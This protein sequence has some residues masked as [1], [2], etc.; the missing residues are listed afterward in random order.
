M[1]RA[2]S[3]PAAAWAWTNPSILPPSYCPAKAA[4]DCANFGTVRSPT[5][6]GLT[7]PLVGF[8]T[9]FGMH[10]PGGIPSAPGYVPNR[11]SYERPSPITKTACWIGVLVCGGEGLAAT[12]GETT[13]HSTKALAAKA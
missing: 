8:A 7:H 10:V 1:T 12:A 3:D 11:L 4:S 6:N 5:H 2:A 13:L 9:S